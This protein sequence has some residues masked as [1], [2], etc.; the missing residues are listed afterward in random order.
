V[1]VSIGRRAR[2]H[3][4][5][6]GRP[7][8]V[9]ILGAEQ[10]PVAR[11]FAGDPHPDHVRWVEHDVAPRLAGVLAFIGCEP[12]QAYDGGDHT[13]FLGRVVDLEYRDG[14]ALGYAYSRFTRLEEPALG[15]EYIFG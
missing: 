6:A 14:A 7:F 1:L 4:L 5:V 12:W 3:D 11:H 13:L 2:G 10:E 8:G 15:M 9:N